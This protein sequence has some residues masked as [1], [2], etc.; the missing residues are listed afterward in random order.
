M[1]CA[2]E[3]PFGVIIAKEIIEKIEGSEIELWDY[4]DCAIKQPK[5]YLSSELASKISPIVQ[6]TWKGLSE[7]RKSLFKLLSRF[8]I[9]IEQVCI[10]MV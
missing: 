6:K 8:S 1:F 2:I 7:E 4:V 5:D 10:L 3:M 9:T